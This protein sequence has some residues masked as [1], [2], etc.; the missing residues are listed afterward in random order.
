MGS[1]A[2]CTTAM[3]EY[4]VQIWCLLRRGAYMVVVVQ[5]YCARLPGTGESDKITGRDIICGEI[6]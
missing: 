1:V 5:Q 4:Q 6:G 2:K 3:Q